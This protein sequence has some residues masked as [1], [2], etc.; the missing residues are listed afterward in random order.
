MALNNINNSPL[1]RPGNLYQY[2][3][4]AKTDKDGKTEA[5]DPRLSAT[6]PVKTTDKAEISDAAHRLIELRKDVDTGRDSIEALPDIRQDK[7]DQAKKRLEQGFY[8]SVEVQ[9]KIAEKLGSVFTK[10]DEI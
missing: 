8:N 6:P 10:M 5:P 3:G 4:T 7:V 2:K 9:G 1:T